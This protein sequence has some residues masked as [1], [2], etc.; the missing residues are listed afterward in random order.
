MSFASLNIA[1]DYPKKYPQEVSEKIVLIN[2]KTGRTTEVDPDKL[3]DDQ[4][5]R[6]L[7]R[8]VSVREIG[9][10]VKTK[11]ENGA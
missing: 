7:E 11:V 4:L 9:E 8:R 3:T 1:R 10:L 2:V 5:A 6:F